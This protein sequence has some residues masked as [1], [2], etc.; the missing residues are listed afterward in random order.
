MEPDWDVVF[1]GAGIA[2]GATAW[3]LLRE[4]PHTRI[5][6]LEK[7]PFFGQES[8]GKS[9]S[10][11]RDIFTS[12]V[13]RQLARHSIA[14]YRELD[15][16]L[17]GSEA[18]PDGL[19]LALDG[20]LW[21][22]DA[23]GWE[24]HREAMEA[25]RLEGKVE[26][27]DPDAVERRFLPGFIARVP[28]DL[29]GL[30]L[31]EALAEAEDRPGELSSFADDRAYL[32]DVVQGALGHGCGYLDPT[33]LANYYFAEVLAHPSVRIEYRTEVSEVL[34]RS[35][36]V[37]G[38]RAAGPA[39]DRVHRASGVVIAAGAFA[40]SLLEPYGVAGFV[41]PR[42]R[43]LF[44]FGGEGI[45]SLL[46]REERRRPFP[47]VVL[48]NRCYFRPEGSQMMVGRADSIAPPE[49]GPDGARFP[50]VQ[51]ADDR[52]FTHVV[53]PLL[54]EHIPQFRQGTIHGHGCGLY[55]YTPDRTPIVGAVPGPEGLF[56]IGGFS[57]SGIMKAHASG[58]LMARILQGGE[59]VFTAEGETVDGR[60]LGFQ[61][62]ARTEDLVRE[63]FI[64]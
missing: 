61:R 8:T 35:G 10:A 32:A 57:G 26:F 55:E 3:H 28:E 59:P 20:Y 51:W 27:L 34:E 49:S 16:E 25:M 30:K 6:L 41:Q 50:Y 37:S 24:K 9:A 56:M 40:H 5:L 11:V 64:I 33:A 22:F 53:Q 23:E 18:F 44:T 36:R 21:L 7:L 4:R 54:A 47:L 13:N 12:P 60:V 29:R 42:N 43:M 45:R 39:G 17:R 19:Q 15:R 31:Q 52:Y 46:W 63:S 14:A 1:V 48:Y 38:V 58:L 2:A 62:F